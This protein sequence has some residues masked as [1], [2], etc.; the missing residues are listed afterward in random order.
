[1]LVRPGEK[2]PTDGVVTRGSS[3]VDESM[4]TGEPAPVA[5]S[6]G[7]AVTGATV[8]TTGAF[9]FRAT[10][11][12]A[13]TTFGRHHP[14]GR[15]GAGRETCRFRRWSIA[16]R[17]SSC[18]SIWASPLLTFVVWM[19]IG[20]EPRLTFALVN[21]VAVLI[22][23]CPCAMGLATPAA[24]MTGTGRAAELG[25]LFRKGEALQTLRDVTLIAFDKTG[26]L[27]VGKPR[28][29]DLIAAP[30]F[31]D[32]RRAAAARRERRGAVRASGRA[33]RWSTPRG[34][35]DWRSRPCADFASVPG[36]G[37]AGWSRAESS[38]SAP[39]ATWCRWAS[40]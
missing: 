14:H 31:D 7:A 5:K 8:N 6:E 37:A 40:T 30:G 39:S 38:P 23:A 22:I 11:V 16:S 13:D 29:T 20:P 3:Y 4:I 35:A 15:A 21:A 18:R 1:M 17:A 2:I 19:L 36:M 24:I 9:A 25:V 33:R 10:R 32:E 28:L 26:T 12:G 34:R 27:T